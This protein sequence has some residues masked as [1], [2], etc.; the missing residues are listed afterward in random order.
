VIVPI[1]WL[2]AN[3][4][5]GLA[6]PYIA[7]KNAEEACALAS[8]LFEKDGFTGTI[9]IL[10]EAAVCPTESQFYVDQFIKAI[11][12]LGTNSSLERRKQLTL[13]FKP[14]MFCPA[15]T[16]LFP[17]QK[18]LDLGYARME[19]VVKYAF[20]HNINMTLEAEDANWADYQLDSFFS[21]LNSGYSNLGTVLQSRLFRT[22]KDI[23]R[24]KHKR[25]RLVIGIYEETS[26]IAYTDK[27][28]M[29]DLLIEYG[30]QLLDKDNYVELATHDQIYIQK[31]LNDVIKPFNISSGRFEFQFLL[32]V[33]RYKLQK[34]LI[35]GGNIVRLYLP[36][37]PEA[38]SVPYCKRRLKTNPNLLWY[39]I[40]NL[41]GIQQ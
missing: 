39:G 6:A 11:D 12:L 2:P 14:S 17:D 29:K 33:P 41:L 15:A 1:D 40:K 36:F 23:E 22:A 5:L 19:Q 8:D 18:N 21:L 28:Q 38:I 35:E 26:D 9:D 27:I 7:G 24:F 3:I 30:R 16:H 32:G 31:F 20:T 10:G 13:S 25:V 37:G 4:V 34:S